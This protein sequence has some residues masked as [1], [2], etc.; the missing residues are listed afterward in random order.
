MKRSPEHEPLGSTALVGIP[1]HGLRLTYG[2]Q[3]VR[4]FPVSDILPCRQ[5]AK[6]SRQ[7]HRTSITGQP[8]GVATCV[9]RGERFLLRAF[10]RKPVPELVREDS[11]VHHS[12]VDASPAPRI[13]VHPRVPN[14][15][16]ARAARNPDVV[17]LR[18]AGQQPPFPGCFGEAVGKTAMRGDPLA[19]PLVRSLAHAVE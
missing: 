3:R 17:A 8:V 13:L 19:K 5:L 6:I 10:S 14:Q 11:R 9:V 18:S 4:E 1:L 15:R 16:P 2:L 7:V 12:L